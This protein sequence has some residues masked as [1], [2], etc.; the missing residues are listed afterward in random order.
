MRKQNRS[1]QTLA[2]A[3][4]CELA[5][6]LTPEAGHGSKRTVR[7]SMATLRQLQAT[8]ALV[9]TTTEEAS[10]R[11]LNVSTGLIGI[12]QLLDLWSDRA[13]E[14]RCLHCLLVPL[15]LELDDALSDIQK[16]L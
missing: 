12:L 13:W 2:L 1:P 8:S 6:R 16:M 14:C 11:L 3:Q 9:Y 10:A 15:K 5:Q 7:A 4:L